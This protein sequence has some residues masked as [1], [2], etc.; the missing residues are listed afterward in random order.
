MF[1]VGVLYYFTYILEEDEVVFLFLDVYNFVPIFKM[2]RKNEITEI[3]F[4]Q[5]K[6]KIK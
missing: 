4:K 3:I 6:I 5:C 2:K 1:L